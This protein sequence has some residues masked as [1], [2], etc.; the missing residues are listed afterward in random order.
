MN[1][2]LVEVSDGELFDKIS[3][4]EIKKD[5]IKNLDKLKFINDEYEVLKSEPQLNETGIDVC[6]RMTVSISGRI[7]QFGA[8]TIEG[9]NNKSSNNSSAILQT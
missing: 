4:L 5:R 2:I 1:K 8:R 7:A 6:Y 9:V 3:N